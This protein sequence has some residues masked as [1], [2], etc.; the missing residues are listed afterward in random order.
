VQPLI[1]FTH[2]ISDPL[3]YHVCAFPFIASREHVSKLSS[4]E[5]LTTRMGV[6]KIGNLGAHTFLNYRGFLLETWYNT[7]YFPSASI[8]SLPW[9]S[10]LFL[11]RDPAGHTSQKLA[12]ALSSP[13]RARRYPAAQRPTA[14]VA[15]VLHCSCL[16]TRCYPGAQ[17]PTKQQSM[18]CK[19][20]KQKAKHT[21]FIL[22]LM[23]N[24]T[25]WTHDKEQHKTNLYSLHILI[26]TPSIF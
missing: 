25:H 17:K 12:A 6:E 7:L 22:M 5:N 9:L 20:H 26:Y 16:R 23:N 2:E 13:T 4:F 3:I 24:T 18:K 19:F 14:G 8:S 10:W 11:H 1:C 21:P 15:V